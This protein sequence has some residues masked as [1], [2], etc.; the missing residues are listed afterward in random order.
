MVLNAETL[1]QYFRKFPVF[2]LPGLLLLSLTACNE[3][4]RKVYPSPKGYELGEPEQKKLPI[5]LDEIS[6]I[7]Y[8]AEDEALFAIQDE[9]GLLYK[10][11][12]FHKENIERWR[13]GLSGDY[14]DV[15]LLNNKFYVLKS[16]G[17]I[18]SFNFT[19]SGKVQGAEYPM[20]LVSGAEFESLYYE[21]ELRKLVLICKDCPQ[22]KKKHVSTYRFDPETRLFEAAEMT[23][24]AE[25][26]AGAMGQKSMKF[27]PSAAAVHPLTGKLFIISAVNK[28][29]VVTD[30]QGRTQ[31]VYLLP[32]VY[33]KQPEGIAFAPDG[34]MFIS[35]E[36]ADVGVADILIYQY[37]RPETPR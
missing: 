33:H 16:N 20:N 14:E 21:P 28:L 30:R 24:D 32:P 10:I 23:I 15:V 6:G 5:E 37:T 36:A 12:P 26:I 34:T 2:V 19:D 1:F 31:E 7:A 3:P 4:P 18:A 29:L 8:H 35:N 27:K 13:F 9:T 11:R 17:N 25:G 22:D